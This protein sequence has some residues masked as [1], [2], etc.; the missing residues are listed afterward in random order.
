MIFNYLRVSTILQ[1][2]ERQLPSVDC[3][4]VY[5]DK[6]SGKDTQR[7]QFQLM[8]S[9]LR[10]GDVVNVHSLDR[11]G[12]NT[13]DI[14]DIVQQ[15]KDLNC[16]IHFHKENLRFDGTKSDLYS[17]LLLS[18]LSSFSEF[19]RNIMLERQRE[20]IEIAK[21]KGKY[22][23]G[24]E[25][26]TESEKGEIQELVKEGISISEISRTMNCSRPTIYKVIGNTT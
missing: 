4:R 5:E 14:L 13:K 20:G 2:T 21:Q 1:N 22:K 17:N 3:D 7:P 25:R 19:E 16:V 12:R 10:E 9:N 18:I 11:I 15:I 6:L 23:G 8:M 24:K 26:F